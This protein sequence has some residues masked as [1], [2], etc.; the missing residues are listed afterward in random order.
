MM[1]DT[2]DKPLNTFGLKE[3]RAIRDRWAEMPYEEVK[4][5]WEESVERVM[6]ERH[7][8]NWRAKIRVIG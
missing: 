2:V 1:T 3:I 7:G 8:K 4:A 5:E 6:T